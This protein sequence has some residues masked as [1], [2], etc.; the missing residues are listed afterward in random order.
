VSG[1]VSE[2]FDGVEVWRP[3]VGECGKGGMKL[4]LWRCLFFRHGH[5]LDARRY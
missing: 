4:T 3:W 2:V 1:G 5:S